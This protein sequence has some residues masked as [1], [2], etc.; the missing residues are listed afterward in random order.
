[1]QRFPAGYIDWRPGRHVN[2]K[3]L[4][5]GLQYRGRVAGVRQ[6]YYVFEAKAYFFVLSF[7]LSKAHKGS[8]YFNMVNQE[9]V[10]YTHSRFGGRSGVTAKGVV[11]VARRTKHVPTSLAALNIL[12]I[13]VALK[14][15]AILRSGEHRQLFF[16]VRK[17]P[18]PLRSRR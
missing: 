9:A 12:Y 6:T 15:A 18:R 16:S 11:A 1:M 14:Q 8:G 17:M 10:N 13:L 2:I 5:Q 7:A 3:T 4:Q